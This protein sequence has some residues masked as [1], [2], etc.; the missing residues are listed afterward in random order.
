M[1]LKKETKTKLLLLVLIPLFSWFLLFQLFT[2]EKKNFDQLALGK[3]NFLVT[4]SI[5]KHKIICSSI[6]G[7]EDCLNYLRKKNFKKN[8]LWLGNSQLNSVN[9]GDANTILASHKVSQYFYNKNVGVITF[10]APN[11]SFQEYFTVISHLKNKFYFDALIL[12]LVFD[13]TREDGIRKSFIIKKKNKNIKKTLQEMSESKIIS[14]LN[15][16]LKWNNVRSAAQ[17]NIYEFLYR[18]RNFVFNINPTTTRKTIKPIFDKN[19]LSLEKILK[20][21][22]KDSIKTIL[23][24]APLRNDIKIPYNEVEYSLFKKRTKD[25]SKE[26][27]SNFYNLED[28]VPAPLWGDKG[29]TKLG[30]VKEVDFM[31]F[32]EQ[33]HAILSQ[34]IITILDKLF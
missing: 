22:K 16:Y 12:P 34:N 7:L 30:V 1:S 3:N 13:D 5:N 23:Y 31:H 4:N 28:V 8:I 24:I 11:I 19:M 32:K 29:G 14:Y 20:V 18:G 9:Q 21:A 15:K 27:F 33:G 6:E 26:Y 10:A 2:G 17:G 25:L